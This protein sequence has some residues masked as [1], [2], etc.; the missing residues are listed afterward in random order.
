MM[1]FMVAKTVAFL[2]RPC[3][4]EWFWKEQG[5]RLQAEKPWNSAHFRQTGIPSRRA[6]HLTLDCYFLAF[7]N[8]QR[9]KPQRRFVVSLTVKHR[10]EHSMMT[11]K[12]ISTSPFICKEFF[13]RLFSNQNLGLRQFENSVRSWS[14]CIHFEQV[15]SVKRLK[16][17]YMANKC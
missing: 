16:P 4:C 17:F 8:W 6:P 1:P 2:Q 7:V 12:F 10:N 11:I 3:F 13:N 14:L 5:L 9:N 15:E